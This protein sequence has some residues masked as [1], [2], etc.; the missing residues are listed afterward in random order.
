M[1][2]TKDVC[3]TLKRGGEE[4]WRNLKLHGYLILII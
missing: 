1:L 4:K 3:E 2:M